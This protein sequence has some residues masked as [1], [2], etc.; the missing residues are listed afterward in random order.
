[1]HHRG[2]AVW[3]GLTPGRPARAGTLRE[4]RPRSAHGG[5]KSAWCPSRAGVAPGSAGSAWEATAATT[6]KSVTIYLTH[7]RRAPDLGEVGI[8]AR[9]GVGVHA[10]RRRAEQDLRLRVLAR[11]AGVHL[12]ARCPMPQSPKCAIS[13]RPHL[14]D[15]AIINQPRPHH[16]TKTYST[17]RP[18]MNCFLAPRACR[19]VIKLPQT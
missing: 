17:L 5:S 8:V 3:P 6:L 10:R 18:R 14:P 9:G 16:H 12:H 19:Q 7:C 11:L 4:G 13:R 2:D 1:M 15:P